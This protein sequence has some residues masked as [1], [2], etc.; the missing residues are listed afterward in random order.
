MY[1]RKPYP[2]ELYHHGIMGQK[3]GVRRYQN[4]DGSLTL[5]GKRRY[6]RKLVNEA[7]MSSF[8]ANGYQKTAARY[9]KKAAKKYKRV[10]DLSNKQRLT[11]RSANRYNNAQ[12]K[13]RDAQS[14]AD[15][16]TKKAENDLKTA[17]KYTQEI[18]KEHGK[19][20][21]KD[22]PKDIINAAKRYEN[23]NS[24]V[25]YDT[26]TGHLR[27]IPASLPM[28]Y[29]YNTEKSGKFDGKHYRKIFNKLKK[30]SPNASLY[31]D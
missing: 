30:N 16:W 3:W 31:Y 7:L 19:I 27:Y 22:V 1:I 29:R 14:R 21:V 4:P 17:K 15:F 10:V 28:F 2:N 8:A 24:Y 25:F 5:A 12:A 6:Q 9:D 23:E 11:Q 13:Y 20:K 26:S 18:I